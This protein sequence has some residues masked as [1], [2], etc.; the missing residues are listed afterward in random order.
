MPMSVVSAMHVTI[1][2]IFRL[3]DANSLRNEVAF[4]KLQKSDFLSGA[5]AKFIAQW[6]SIRIPQERNL[7]VSQL[8]NDIRKGVPDSKRSQVT[9]LIFGAVKCMLI[10]PYDRCGG[11]W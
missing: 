5:R 3:K 6:A 9:F 2:G 1:L 8:R 4:A 11:Q 10:H 7:C